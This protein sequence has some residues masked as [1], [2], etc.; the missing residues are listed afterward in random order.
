LGSSWVVGGDMD[1][2]TSGVFD[3]IVGAF[4]GSVVQYEWC[5]NRKGIRSDRSSVVLGVCIVWSMYGE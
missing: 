5:R 4:V 1:V 2:D 3:V